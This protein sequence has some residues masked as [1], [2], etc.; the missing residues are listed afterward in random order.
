MA[1]HPQLTRI[2]VKRNMYTDKPLLAGN[3]TGH[4][5]SNLGDVSGHSSVSVSWIFLHDGENLHL[6]LGMQQC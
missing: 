1:Q 2:E 6:I 5:G 3:G 4:G